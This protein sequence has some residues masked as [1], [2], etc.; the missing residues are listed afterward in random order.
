MA[1]QQPRVGPRVSAQEEEGGNASKTF[2]PK[3]S[4]P[5]GSTE[6]LPGNVPPTEA[7]SVELQLAA[8]IQD[9]LIQSAPPAVP[10][11]MQET[12]REELTP[13]FP[14]ELEELLKALR[15]EA[16]QEPYPGAT[17]PLVTLRWRLYC[18]TREP[19]Q[20]STIPAAK[21]RAKGL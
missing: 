19:L 11:S 14:P 20:H 2:E 4:L 16:F 5:S 13:D 1:L 21:D 3:S 8:I 6:A 18:P 12:L 7:R 15:A 17:D 10:K 9:Q